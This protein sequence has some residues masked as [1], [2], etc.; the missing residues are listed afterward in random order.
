M[1]WKFPFLSGAVLLPPPTVVSPRPLHPLQLLE[2][3]EKVPPPPP[4]PPG[5]AGQPSV[6]HLLLDLDL[7]LAPAIPWEELVGG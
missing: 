6:H 2:G 3:L 4:A 5:S 7:A 1:T